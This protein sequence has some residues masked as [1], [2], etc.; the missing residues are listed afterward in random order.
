M[1][2]GLQAVDRFSLRVSF[3]KQFRNRKSV[4]GPISPRRTFAMNNSLDFNLFS[5]TFGEQNF[6]D[7]INSASGKVEAKT[8]WKKT[9]CGM[10][11]V[12]FRSSKM[13]ISE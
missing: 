12:V 1:A 6:F 11:F 13:N 8:Q 2:L 5:G 10:E 4:C 9:T 3:G 7:Y